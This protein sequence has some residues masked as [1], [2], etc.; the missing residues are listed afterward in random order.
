MH[1]SALPPRR[2]VV[3]LQWY[4]SLGSIA[5]YE[6]TETGFTTPC[7]INKWPPIIS[8]WGLTAEPDL[9]YIGAWL[10]AA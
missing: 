3:T 5:S 2:S 1:V 8:R 7:T 6:A 10:L 9:V 4:M